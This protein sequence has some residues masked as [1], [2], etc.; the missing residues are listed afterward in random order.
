MGLKSAKKGLKIILS[1]PKERARF[2]LAKQTKAAVQLIPA[3]IRFG[4]SAMRARKL[5]RRLQNVQDSKVVNST[6]ASKRKSR[7]VT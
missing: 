6:F 2:N 1:S 4:N 5:R 3:T 7:N